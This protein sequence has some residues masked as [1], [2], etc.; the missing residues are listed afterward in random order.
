MNANASTVMINMN[1]FHSISSIQN[2][3][4]LL[5]PIDNRNGS[6]KV[7][8]RR[9]RY[10]VGWYNLREQERIYCRKSDGLSELVVPGL[11]TNELVMKP[12]LWSFKDVE[13]VFNRLGNVDLSVDRVNGII[14]LIVPE[15]WELRM[16]DGLCEL[17]GLDDGKGGEWLVAGTYVGDRTVDFS[18]IRELRVHLDQL[19]TYQNYA[20]G[21]PSTILDVV[22]VGAQALGEAGVYEQQSPQ[23]KPLEAGT[24]SELK[25]SIRDH[26]GKPLDNH[27][28]PIAVELE[29]CSD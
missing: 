21:R 8:L 11:A 22:A 13:K 12:G 28:Q 5:Q 4:Q 24:I 1:L 2:A 23:Y 20:D 14:S 10:R 15:G 17:L 9:L 29:I 3:V 18:P 27:G 6:L 25:V 7:G 26:R 16:P 19:S